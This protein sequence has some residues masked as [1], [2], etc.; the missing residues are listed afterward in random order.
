MKHEGFN[1][2]EIIRFPCSLFSLNESLLRVV[3][4]RVPKQTIVA[5]TGDKPGVDDRCV[6][7][8]RAK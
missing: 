4:D 8:H 2:I 3:R 5:R 1:Y 7:V 6:L